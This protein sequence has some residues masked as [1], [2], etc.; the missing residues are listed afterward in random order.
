MILF[1]FNLPSNLFACRIENAA[2]IH[3]FE[4]WAFEWEF[5]FSVD[6][7]KKQTKNLF[8]YKEENMSRV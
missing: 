8:F 5:R 4:K 6:K 7:Y 1:S 2:S 3:I